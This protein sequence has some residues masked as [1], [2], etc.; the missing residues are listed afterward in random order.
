MNIGKLIKG[1]VKLHCS[2]ITIS[3]IDK[4]MLKFMKKLEKNKYFLNFEKKC[5]RK[6]KEEKD[7]RVSEENK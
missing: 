7:K 1:Q 2:I 6:T 5:E 3:E 4:D